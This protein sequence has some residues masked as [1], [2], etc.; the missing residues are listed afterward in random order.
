MLKLFLLR[1]GKAQNPIQGQ[2]DYDRPLNKKGVVQ[3]NQ[4]GA[5]FN[6]TDFNVEQIISSKAKR[7]FETA[8]IMNHYLK[9]QDIEYSKELY[10]ANEHEILE[11]IKTHGKA[12]ELLYV[13]H[14]F[15][16]SNIASLFTGSSLSLTTGM[17]VEFQFD[18][19][20]WNSIDFGKGTSGLIKA[21][22][23]YLP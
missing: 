5:Y 21:P 22:N 9:V 12:K 16:I 2:D 14:N 4:I 15:G 11:H 19:K 10:L 18:V 23:I 1:H 8:E 13:G 7:T 6:T 17:L 20:D 3:I